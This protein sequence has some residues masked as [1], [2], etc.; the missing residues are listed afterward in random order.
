MAKL[1]GN[2]NIR[3]ALCAVVVLLA[4]ALTGCGASVTVYDYTQN[5]VRYN[6]VEVDIDVTTLAAMES[7]AAKTEYDYTVASYLRELFETFGYTLESSASNDGGYTV[8]Y[9]KAFPSNVSDLDLLGT[10]VEFNSTYTENPFTRKVEMTAKNPFN[11]MRA[12]FDNAEP[13]RSGTA[14]ELIKNG[15]V[16]VNEYGERVVLIP[17]ITDAFPCLRG[18][19]VEGLLLHYVRVGS[20]RMRSSGQSNLIDGKNSEYVFSRYFDRAENEISFT[21]NRPVVY[22]WYIVALVAGGITIGIVFLVTRK[23]KDKGPTLMERFPY[24]PEEYRDYE[25]HLPMN[26]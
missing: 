23:K 12:A 9:V 6:G 21:Y 7:S 5:D 17:A 13:N 8:R 3:L 19:N 1:F 14:L 15:R 10:V 22:G 18:E 24:N 4:C 16:A 26:K 11:G 25:S 2:K 20:K